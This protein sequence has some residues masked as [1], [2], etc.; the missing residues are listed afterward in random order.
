MTAVTNKFTSY[1]LTEEEYNS[2]SMFSLPQQQCLQNLLSEAA[3]LRLALDFDPLNPGDFVQQEAFLKGKI[4]L[5][6]YLLENSNAVEER[7][8]EQIALQ[9]FNQQLDPQ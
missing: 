8:R 7:V 6:S 5:L 1:Q 9:R 3:H 4:E 2:G